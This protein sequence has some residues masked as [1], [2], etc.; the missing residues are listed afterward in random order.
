MQSY[1]SP[2]FYQP[3]QHLLMPTMIGVGITSGTAGLPQNNIN[4]MH[5]GACCKEGV[6]SITALFRVT[7]TAQGNQWAEA[8]IYRGVFYMLPTGTTSL[9]GSAGPSASLERL[10][11]T[12]IVS[13]IAGTAGNKSVSI[14]LNT[15]TSYGDEIWFA[16]GASSSTRQP[17]FTA[18]RPDP[19]DTGLYQTMTSQISLASTFTGDRGLTSQLLPM[20]YL[21]IG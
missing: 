10:G 14:F 7:L 4:A 5:M 6:T 21:Y 12:S 13:S 2:Q 15:P 19:L 8:G 16:I 11:Y 20:V 3:F 9:S 18:I 17:E 1:S